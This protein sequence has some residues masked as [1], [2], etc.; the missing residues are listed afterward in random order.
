MSEIF[1]NPSGV[2]VACDVPLESL[3]QLVE[4]THDVGGIVGYKIGR[5]HEIDGSVADAIQTVR[6]RTD[7]PVIWDVQKEGNDVE[8]TESEFID[9]YAQA[10]VLSLIL[11]SF[12]SPR[13]QATC[14][15]ACNE[16]GITP[17]GGFR[18]T[19]K[20]FD[21]TE[22]VTLGDI[23][24]ELGDR[25]FRGYIAS[26][27]EQ[28]AL[29]LY[30]LIGVNHFIG[31]GNKLPELTWMLQT[32]RKYGA[33]PRVLMPGIG[34]Q[35]GDIETAIKTAKDAGAAGYYVII[36]SGIYKA[37]NPRVAAQTYASRI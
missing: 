26:D 27:A 16:N 32:L 5:M 36:G 4:Q 9:R 14:I 15:R 23:F 6:S 25:E 18:L 37:E 24:P 17:I 20:G 34:R 3:G 12:S 10:G 22:V 8:V 29:E 19:Q 7:K 11:F 33:E 13:V 28:R 2:I 30:T 1:T 21:E 35:G 31:P